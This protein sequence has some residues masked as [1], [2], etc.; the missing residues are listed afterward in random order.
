MPK[1]IELDGP[2]GSE[3]M[4]PSPPHSGATLSVEQLPAFLVCCGLSVQ[5]AAFVML[6]GYLHSEMCDSKVLMWSELVKLTV[7]VILAGQQSSLLFERAH[8]AI[9]PVVRQRFNALTIHVGMQCQTM[10]RHSANTS[11][12]QPRVH[13]FQVC[14]VLAGNVWHHEPT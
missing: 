11:T 4:L 8:L 2:E 14:D 12:R 3:Q 6:R 5:G 13:T 1:Y 9:L 10:P 7:S